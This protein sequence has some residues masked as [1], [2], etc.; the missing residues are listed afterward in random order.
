MWTDVE[1]E[2]AASFII[3][4]SLEARLF[5]DG[6]EQSGAGRKGKEE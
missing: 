1:K 3:R 2:F 5:D 6:A 4:S